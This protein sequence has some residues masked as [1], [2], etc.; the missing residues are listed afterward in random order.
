M[1][2]ADETNGWSEWSKFVLKELERLNEQCDQL[3]KDHSNMNEKFNEKTQEIKTAIGMLGTEMRLK[4]GIWGALAG[5]I[6]A[7]LM[8]IYYW[9]ARKP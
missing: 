8:L 5:L 9:V 6:P 1:V 3:R 7:I 2:K 4:S